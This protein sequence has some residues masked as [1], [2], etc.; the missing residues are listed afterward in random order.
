MKQA[1]AI[2]AK[3]MT[4]EISRIVTWN[5]PSIAACSALAALGVSVS[6][7]PMPKIKAKNITA[8]MSLSAAAATTLLGMMAR[9]ASTPC[10]FSAWPLRIAP[11]PSR[12]SVE[13]FAA[14]APGRRPRRAGADW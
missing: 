3:R 9:T 4:I 13:Q 2:G 5:M 6:S 10:G 8:R 12:A 1:I 7:R 11:A 14:P